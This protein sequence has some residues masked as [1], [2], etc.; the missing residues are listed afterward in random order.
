MKNN[1]NKMKKKFVETLECDDLCYIDTVKTK[2]SSIES[3]EMKKDVEEQI[4]KKN[5]NC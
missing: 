2:D 3:R 1:D 4:Q 5:C